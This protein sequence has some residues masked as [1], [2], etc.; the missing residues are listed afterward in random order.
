MRLVIGGK[1][2]ILLLMTEMFNL[3]H[4]FKPGMSI[5]LVVYIRATLPS[6]K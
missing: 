6:L 1:T 5:L 4:N 3:E 2:G